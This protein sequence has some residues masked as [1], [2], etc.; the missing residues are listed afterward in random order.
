MA[1]AI[2]NGGRF[3]EFLG[4]RAYAAPE[5]FGFTGYNEK[6]DE[7]AVGII[8]YI[9]LTGIEPFEEGNNLEN[10][11]KFQ[12]IN[13][14]FAKTDGKVIKNHYPKGLRNL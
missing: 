8:M 10:C 11:I 4:T 12:N 1:A 7:W 6:V 3:R 14:D 9:M 2:P 13:V 5:I